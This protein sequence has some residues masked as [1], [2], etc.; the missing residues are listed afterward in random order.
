VKQ[1]I[2]RLTV[3]YLFPQF[4][5]A[6][7]AQ[8]CQFS[9]PVIRDASHYQNNTDDSFCQGLCHHVTQKTYNFPDHPGR[10]IVIKLST[11]ISGYTIPVLYHCLIPPRMALIT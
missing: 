7:V 2:A 1:F 9:H 5:N 11:F 4:P 10:D 6:S 3:F 8:T